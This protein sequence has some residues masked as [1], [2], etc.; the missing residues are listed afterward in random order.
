MIFLI[1]GF[2]PLAFVNILRL[3]HCFTWFHDDLLSYGSA[4]ALKIDFQLHVRNERWSLSENI[5]NYNTQNQN[6]VSGFAI[7]FL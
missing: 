3:S 4:N 1:C 6:S 7:N 2:N 5:M